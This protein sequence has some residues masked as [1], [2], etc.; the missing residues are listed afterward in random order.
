MLYPLHLLAA[1]GKDGWQVVDT[2]HRSWRRTLLVPRQLCLFESIPC[3]SVH[4][5]ELTGFAQLQARRLS[6]FER[7]GASALRRVGRLHLWLWD[8]AEVDAMF[9]AQTKDATSVQRAEALYLPWPVAGSKLRRTTQ[10]DE[11]V[12]LDEAGALLYS[13]PTGHA[14]GLDLSVLLPRA[15]GHDWL[16]GSLDAAAVRPAWA[17]TVALLNAV[18]MTAAMA[19]L[20][21][22][23]YEGG[24]LWGTLNTAERLEERVARQAA[25][26]GES[27][28]IERSALADAQWIDTYRRATAQLDVGAALDALRA[29][30]EAYGVAIR[31]L[32]AAGTELRLTLVSAGGEIRIAELLQALR[33]VAGVRS[34]SLHQHKEL[35]WAVYIVD[36][37]AF[38]SGA[39][40]QRGLETQ[41]AAH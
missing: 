2:G 31:E 18:G 29:A 38:A 11:E 36:M 32:D 34:A 40:L 17:G 14:P 26:R 41:R 33:A 13:E 30:M 19:M 3:G 1:D 35:E 9:A 22:L 20:V 15:A 4:W 37:P 16:G 39:R 5:Y 25:T 12:H 24:R 7:T 6:P 23:G 21:Y 8:A 27:A 10:I 28:R